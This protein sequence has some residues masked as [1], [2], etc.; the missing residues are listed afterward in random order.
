[1]CTRARVV[2]D[3]DTEVLD[4]QGLLFVD[5]E[6]GQWVAPNAC[7]L[8]SCKGSTHK[9]DANNFTIGFFDLLQLSMGGVNSDLN[10]DQ[11]WMHLRKYQNLDFA[12]TSLVA[13][14]RIR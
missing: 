4:F 11:R 10:W 5:L 1:M 9:I 2:A 13:K 6:R 14:M 3:P 8:N 12:T 7:L